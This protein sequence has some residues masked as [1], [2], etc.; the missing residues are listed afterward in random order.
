MASAE[1]TGYTHPAVCTTVI[2]LWQP[3]IN[4]DITRHLKFLHS[5]SEHLDLLALPPDE[6]V[7]DAGPRVVVDGRSCSGLEEA[8]HEEE[9]RTGNPSR[10]PILV[11]KKKCTV[12]SLFFQCGEQ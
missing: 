12:Q 2:K 11:D 3:S 6:G 4:I 1:L 7:Q 5:R 9:G 8:V 10:A